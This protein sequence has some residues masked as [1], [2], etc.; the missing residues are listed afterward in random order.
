MRT[1]L[2]LKWSSLRT[3]LDTRRSSLRT[4]LDMRQ[5]LLRSCLQC[6]EGGRLGRATMSLLLQS[7]QIQILGRLLNQSVVRGNHFLYSHSIMVIHANT[8]CCTYLSCSSWEDTTFW[9]TC[10]QRQVNAILGNL[11]HMHYPGEVTWSDGT[12]SLA[13]C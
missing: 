5:S 4:P 9:G 3:H 8:N 10:H 1:P 2:D 6:R 11:V 12:T 7:L 13:T